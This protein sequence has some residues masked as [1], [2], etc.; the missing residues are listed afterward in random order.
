LG[1]HEQPNSSGVFSGEAGLAAFMR[2]LLTGYALYGLTKGIAG[3]GI[4]SRIVI[5]PLFARN[6]GEI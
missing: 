3:S 2:K 4:S 5:T 1:S 6:K